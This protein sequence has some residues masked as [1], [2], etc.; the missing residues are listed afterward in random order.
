MTLREHFVP[1]RLAIWLCR[2]FGHG[3]SVWR[4]RPAEV[5]AREVEEH[6]RE[7]V[8]AE[9]TQ[10]MDRVARGLRPT[11]KPPAVA[12]RRSPVASA[13]YRCGAWA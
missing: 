3:D 9:L 13:C 6:D 2:V 1:S 10:R 12:P 5:I 4:M 11:N 7:Y 8:D